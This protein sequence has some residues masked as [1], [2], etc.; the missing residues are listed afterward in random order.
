MN[1]MYFDSIMIY[2]CKVFLHLLPGKEINKLHTFAQ[3]NQN[4]WICRRFV[5]MILIH[6]TK[7]W[8][9]VC[10]LALIYDVIKITDYLEISHHRIFSKLTLYCDNSTVDWPSLLHFVQEFWSYH[11]VQA[12]SSSC[13]PV[14]ASL[15]V[16]LGASDHLPVDRLSYQMA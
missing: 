7:S 16:L 8:Y 6:R 10:G 4:Q 1:L 13:P 2:P 14:I 11:C 3:S 9:R 5:C 15:L 12:D